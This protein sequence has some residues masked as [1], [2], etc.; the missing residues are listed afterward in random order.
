MHT[1][2]QSLIRPD[3]LSES[4][5]VACHAVAQVL[6]ILIMLTCIYNLELLIPHIYIIKLRFTGI[7]ITFL[8]FFCSKHI[9]GAH[10]NGIIKVV[11][12]TTHNL[13]FEQK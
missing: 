13:C 12:T 3:R 10:Y 6:S 7:Y 5:L 9:V 4:L 11:L 8:F 1:A 2:L